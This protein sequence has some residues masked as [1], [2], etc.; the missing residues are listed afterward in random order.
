MQVSHLKLSINIQ[1]RFFNTLKFY[2]YESL[3]SYLSDEIV[4]CN[5]KIT[6]VFLI[7]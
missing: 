4:F 5:R 6:G 3:T 2:V 1:V 7:K